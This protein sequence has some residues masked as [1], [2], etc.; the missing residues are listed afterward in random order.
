MNSFHSSE[1]LPTQADSCADGEATFWLTAAKFCKITA[2]KVHHHIVESLIAATADK[3][4][5]M[6]LTYNNKTQ[7]AL[8]R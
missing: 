1:Q 5:N 4:T 6:I 3:S 7:Y 2:L 8:L